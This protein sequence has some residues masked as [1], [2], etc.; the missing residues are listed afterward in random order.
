MLTSSNQTDN[1]CPGLFGH[2]LKNLKR[3]TF[4]SLVAVLSAHV[5]RIPCTLRLVKNDH[6]RSDAKLLS[7][8]SANLKDV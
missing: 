3:L 5:F 4:K 7:N 8:H 1:D 6:I 2:L